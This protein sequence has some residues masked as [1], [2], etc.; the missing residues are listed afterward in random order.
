MALYIPPELTDVI[1]GFIMDRKTLYNCCLVSTQ[2]LPASRQQLFRAID[3]DSAERCTL[4]IARVLHDE[5]QRPYLRL[6]RSLDLSEG[7]SLST[8]APRLG[9]AA[10]LFS[11]AGQLPALVELTIRAK[12]WGNDHAFLTEPLLFSQ[13]SSLHK[14]VLMVCSFP[15]FAYVR[16]VITALPR[17]RDLRW[18][19]VRSCLGHAVFQPTPRPVLH[20]LSLTF[21]SEG[22]IDDLVTW[23][24]YTPSCSSIRHLS[25]HPIPPGDEGL[26]GYDFTSSQHTFFSAVGPHVTTLELQSHGALL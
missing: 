8:K 26:P 6:V 12:A 24:L 3:L 22:D 7:P 11:L 16:R 15:S 17:L 23:L 20:C 14:L 5:S 4:F 9:R 13:F 1:I 10:I 2:W 25:F 18:R 19:L 21:S